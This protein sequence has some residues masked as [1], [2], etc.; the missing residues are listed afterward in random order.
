MVNMEILMV[1]VCLS[2]TINKINYK[3]YLDRKYLKNIAG[4]RDVTKN[5]KASQARVTF[6]YRVPYLILLY[7]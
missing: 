3:Y 2:N 1:L 7:E 4:T 6:A 5:E